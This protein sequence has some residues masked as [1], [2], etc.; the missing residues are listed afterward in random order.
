MNRTQN[1]KDMKLYQYDPELSNKLH[2]GR[3]PHLLKT[4]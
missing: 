3:S 4:Q 2:Q 1:N